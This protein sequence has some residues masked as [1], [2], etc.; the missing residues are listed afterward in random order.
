MSPASILIVDDT[1]ANLRLLAELLTRAGYRVRS[2]INGT[3]ALSGAIA[4]PPDLILLDIM[5]PDLSG[6]EVCQHL[7]NNQRTRDVPVIFLSALEDAADKVKAFEVGGADYI[8]KP[9]QKAEILA[10]VENQLAMRRLQGQLSEQN[11]QLQAEVRERAAAQQQLHQFSASLKQLHRLDTTPYPSLAARYAD[12]LRTGCQLFGL[13]LAWLSRVQ[14]DHWSLEAS[15]NLPPH[16]PAERL[17]AA[18]DASSTLATRPRQSCPGPWGLTWGHP[19]GSAASSTAP[20][21]LPPSRLGSSPSV[22]KSVNWWNSWPRA[23]ASF[24]P[25]TRKN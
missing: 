21:V 10:R 13:E 14:G 9:F 12:Y 3:L 22:T 19:S 24:S 4:Q 15:D 1:T 18:M 20:W 2:A 17:L 6:Y 7:K 5:M 8:G 23:W 16:L 25:P 11:E